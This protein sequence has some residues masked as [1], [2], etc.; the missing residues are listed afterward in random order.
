MFGLAFQAGDT[1]LEFGPTAG[2]EDASTRVSTRM[3][4]DIAGRFY[5]LTE[6]S[7]DDPQAFLNADDRG[8]LVGTRPSLLPGDAG[9][10]IA[11]G[12]AP[13][14]G[15]GNLGLGATVTYAFRAT[16]PTSMPSDTEGF[17]AFTTAQ[18]TATLMALASW[19]DVANITFVRQDTGSGYS[20][21]AS[22]L[23]GNYSSGS[24]GAAAFAYSPGTVLSSSVSGDVWIN[25]TISV[26]QNPILLNYGMHTLTHEIGH[27]I[28]LHHPA[29]YNAGDGV[30]ISYANDALYYEDSRQY[31][32]MS[33]FGES[34]TGGSF[35]G[36]YSSAPLMD[37]IAAAQRLYGANMTTRTG[38][39]VYG[40]NANA[41]QSWY[42]AATSANRVIFC[43]WDAGGSDTLDF[44]GYSQTQII[45]LRQGGFSSVGG[46]SGNVSIA[47]GAVIENAIGGS[48]QDTIFG[49]S[50]DNVMSGGSGND[51]IDGGLGSDTAVFS[52]ARSSY[53]I[54]W[55][56]T[57]GT[58]VGIDG[59]D[60]VSN[61]EFLRF[62]DQT[63]SAPATT[64]AL[65]VTGDVAANV[66]SGTTFSDTI[67]GAGGADVISGADGDDILEGGW[68]NDQ[69]NGGAGADSLEGGLGADSLD[70][71]DGGDTATYADATTSVVVNLTSGTATGGDGADTL[72]R[73]ENIIGSTFADTLTGDGLAN[74]ILGGGGADAVFGMGGNDLIYAGAPGVGGGAPD[75]VKSGSTINNTIGTAVSLDGGF[76][77]LARSGVAN[78]T[79]TPH[80]TVTAVSHNGVEYYAFTVGNGT[81][82]RFDIDDTSLG[83]DSTLRIFNSAGVEL[84]KNDDGGEV[85]EPS[86][87]SSLS[88]TFD[89]AGT[90]YVQVASWDDNQGGGEFTSKPMNAGTSYTL[91]VSIPNHTVQPT[92]SVG[93]TLDGG[94]GADILTGSV[95]TDWLIGGA[96][97]DVLLGG[98]GNDLLTGGAGADTFKYTARSDSFVGN[99]VA[100]DVIDDF[101][102]GV[103]RIDLVALGLSAVSIA[104]SG[105]YNVVSG[106]TAQGQFSVRVRG[107]VSQT[108]LMLTGQ[109]PGSNPIF[110]T[111]A[112]ETITGTS[113]NDDMTGRGGADT[114][115][116][117][118]GSDRFIYETTSDSSALN[119]ADNLADFET[120]IDRIDL[121]GLNSTSISIIRDG[122]SSFIF[123]ETPAGAFQLL[124]FGR[125]VN[126]ADLTYASQH[127]VFMIGSSGAD[128]L[129]GTSLADPMLGNDGNDILIGRGGADALAGG[130]GADIFRYEHAGD[131]NQTT[132]FDNLY[133]FESGI[134]RI[135]VSGISASSVSIIR[136]DNG[137]SFIFAQSL[138]GDFLTTAAGRAVQGA[139]IITNNTFGIYM[140]GSNNA[141]LLYGTSLADPI[142]GGAGDDFLIGGGGGDVLFGEGGADTYLYWSAA[143]STASAADS[144]F[145]FVTGQDRID[146]RSV[147]TGAN[148]QYGIA[149]QGTG[150]F[151]FVDLGGNGSND[152]LIQ[153][154]NVRLLA[155]DILW[156]AAGA[157]TEPTIKPYLA[158]TLPGLE[159][160]LE[161]GALTGSDEVE[162]YNSHIAAVA[163]NDW[164]M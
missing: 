64:G 23:F 147:R 3:F 99:G 97:D 84:A 38:D 131:S 116:G 137:S 37:D 65:N 96:G 69:L 16:A 156:N 6:A 139:D 164:L 43:V 2:G 66:I 19:S 1:S 160:V 61:V 57:V 31:T 78:A 71:G 122:G 26:N 103:D 32:V 48:G 12:D 80:A 73:I 28:G 5:S 60:T 111:A 90:Y 112:A 13:W 149:Y 17:S 45:D 4:G 127:G 140:I 141:D 79:S 162:L 75:I 145:G 27:A 125:V 34:N 54:T 146:L 158:E 42:A 77:I 33:Y 129:R 132:G 35:S 135:D 70:G 148:D 72:T 8:G 39:T 25:S 115:Y 118:G 105:E 53:T 151:L 86:T 94:D 159:A 100:D 91:H 46:L 52:G 85:G 63:V 150:S 95:S 161:D 114:L 67:R 68:G 9:V 123:A 134:D 117:L 7:G 138:T 59:T 106:S 119:G 124:S 153:L 10:Q 76:D 47:I 36:S 143:D 87:N 83:F 92:T 107:A 14:G 40:F 41:G 157:A 102:T 21:D 98:Q 130:A 15:N 113:G 44:S 55:N 126:G 104:A 110:G 62:D 144:I 24:A 152:M 22:I 155:S 93:S 56:G 163:H 51:S 136:A 133:D 109:T 154:A 101:Q 18:I 50:G 142:Y 30:A 108:D 74:I 128:T 20:D 11:R 81:T 88:F 49:S 82:V 58:I 120:G 29:D 89:T 121:T